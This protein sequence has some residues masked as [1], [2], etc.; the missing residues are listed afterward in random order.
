MPII[1]SNPNKILSVD[2]YGPLPT[3]RG[4]VKYIFVLKDFFK[5]NNFIPDKES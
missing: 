1:P 5:I 2:L 4:G 3:S